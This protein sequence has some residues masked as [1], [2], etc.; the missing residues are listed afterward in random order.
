MITVE[1]LFATEG[2]ARAFAESYRRAYPPQG[3][4]TTTR[5]AEA[6]D[7]RWMVRAKRFSSCD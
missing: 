5:V 3:Y 6:S 7:G 2:A 4:C 1:K